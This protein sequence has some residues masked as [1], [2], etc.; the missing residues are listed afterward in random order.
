[1]LFFSGPLGRL[2]VSFY[3]LGLVFFARVVGESRSRPFCLV[4]PLSRVG[5]VAQ[6]A[7]VAAGRL[8]ALPRCELLLF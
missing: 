6:P 5:H 4:S 2:G 1:M 3:L 7:V 8:V